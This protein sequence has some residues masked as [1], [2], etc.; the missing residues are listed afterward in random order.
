VAG[1]VAIVI[2]LLLL[3]V[4]VCMSGAVGA[5]LLGQTLTKDAEAR[6]EGSELVELNT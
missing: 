6:H 4:I 1:A 3:P 2:V 5:A